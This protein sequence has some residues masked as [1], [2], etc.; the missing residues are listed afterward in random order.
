MPTKQQGVDEVTKAEYEENLIENLNDLAARLASMSY[1]PQPVRRVNIPKGDGKSTRPL[2]IPAYE[3][4][5]VQLSLKMLLEPIFEREF[6]DCSYGFRPGRS[7]PSALRELNSIIERGKIS[8]IVDAD[9][10]SFFDTVDHDWMM[11]CI[12]QRVEDPRIKRLLIR[13]LRAGV[14]VEGEVKPSKRGTP[15]GGLYKALH[16][17]PYAK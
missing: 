16:N 3:D 1:K 5:I 2:G 17:P 10:K 14:M 7:C 11:K 15:Q 9:I 4:K 8:Y 6:L 13:F 12:E